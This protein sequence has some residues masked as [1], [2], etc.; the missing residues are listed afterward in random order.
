[1]DQE[2]HWECRLPGLRRT[3]MLAKHV[4]LHFTLLRPV[5]VAP[6]LLVR[7]PSLRRS[8]AAGLCK[9]FASNARKRKSTC[10]GGSRTQN[11]ISTRR[12]SSRD[13]HICL[14]ESWIRVVTQQYPFCRAHFNTIVMAGRDSSTEDCV[15]SSRS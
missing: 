7:R 9:Y 13:R 14:H 5:F 1:M 15:A 3:R 4:E 6:N 10:D 11:E 12:T 2:Q 8:T